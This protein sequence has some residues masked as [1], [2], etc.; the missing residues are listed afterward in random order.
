M[1]HSA[2]IHHCVDFTLSDV[3]EAMILWA[4]REGLEVP[5]V[6]ALTRNESGVGSL[7]WFTKMATED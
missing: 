7:T 4:N 2:E 3:R 5:S 6:A 1:K